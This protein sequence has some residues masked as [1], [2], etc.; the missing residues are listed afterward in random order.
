MSDPQREWYTSFPSGHAIFLFSLAT[1][2]WFENK[3]AGA[4]LFGIAAL[5]GVGRVAAG[6]HW[7]TDIIGGAALGIAFSIPEINILKKLFPSRH[8][9]R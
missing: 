3:K 7:P 6:V 9:I 8:H 2:V 4:I 1:S 5:V